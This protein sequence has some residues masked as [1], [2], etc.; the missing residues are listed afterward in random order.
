[1]SC[2]GAPLEDEELEQ[3]R[4]RFPGYRGDLPDEARYWSPEDVECF[5]SSDGQVRP[6]EVAKGSSCPLLT[7][8]RQV[9]AEEQVSG[10]T[11][12]YRSFCRHLAERGGEHA[13][14]GAAECVPLERVQRV[15]DRLRAPVLTPC[16]GDWKGRGWNLDFWR[17]EHGGDWW[18]LRA[19]SPMFEHDRSRAD[20][21]EVE[22]SAA[23][24]VD[25]AR[26]L[27]EM[28]PSCR[29]DLAVAYAR[30]AFDSWRP[31]SGSARGLFEGCWRDLAPPGI[32]DLTPRYVKMFAAVF[33]LDWL[34]FLARY[35][36]V[37]L[38]AAGTISRLR[39]ENHGA[40][41]W[42]RQVEGRRLFYLFAPAE[43]TNLHGET[44]GLC[45]GP[46]GYAACASPVDVFFPSE[47]RH[48]Q[49]GQ[50]KA[51]MVILGPGD[52]LVV[53][54]DWWQY[55]V[56]LEASATLHHTFW[57]L[58]NRAHVVEEFREAFLDSQM[59]PELRALAAAN[60]AQLHARI[61]ED[62]DS[63]AED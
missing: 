57:T 4:Q 12:E 19:R 40:H 17:R 42:Y 9:L 20:L 48:A 56:A 37:T 36:K 16:P 30:L 62:D 58:E 51:R 63:D 53:P 38:G 7:R 34:E 47:K 50:A 18:K 39:T 55:S 52:A 54:S 41:A 59:P 24:Y 6:R 60:L 46:E 23:E 10:S 13:L 35:Y 8:V 44:G 3:L 25:Y 5:L 14:P 1:M 11:A 33:N 43:G 28:D 49:F 21:A 45:E 31:F 15:P 26:A 2:L 32:R 29:E 22:G 27:Q 61:L